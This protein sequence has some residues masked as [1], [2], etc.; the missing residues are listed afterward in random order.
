MLGE[1]L[2]NAGYQT[3]CVG[4]T[5]FFPQTK[6]CGFH[7]R[8]THEASQNFD[9]L[10]VNDYR[11]WLRDQS[12][13][14]F[15]EWGHGLQDNSWA[16]RPS[17]L[18]E[19]L[20]N[21][22]WTVTKAIEFLHRRD[23][24]RPYFL[25]VSFFHPHPPFCPPQ[26]FYD[27]YANRDL[28]DVPVG[29]WVD[30]SDHPI[31]NSYASHGVVPPETLAKTRRAYYAQLAHID[32]QIGRLMRACFND[33]HRTAERPWVIFTSDHGEMLG[34][35]HYFRKMFAF[36]G[37]ARIPMIISPPHTGAEV[38][39]QPRRIDAPVAI[40]DVY[41]TI[42]AMAGVEAPTE[43]DGKELLFNL[44][45]DPQECRNL[46]ELEEH[47]D[48]LEMW[49]GRMITELTGRGDGLTD[50]E[51]LIAGT[52]LPPSLPWASSPDPMSETRVV[53]E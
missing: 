35:H 45:D 26:A 47:A 6:H 18:P 51:K 22:T 28:P 10:F 42:L 24:T 33:R 7:S 31:Y 17:H 30:E 20:H 40:E 4:K 49:R 5:H 3:H 46:A 23:T 14:K 34:D 36:E 8:D 29:D 50:G 16:A 2:S 48:T 15:E 44:E 38:H 25:N 19:H 43:I 1:V 32:S 21:N 53:N 39:D 37:S 9:G 13:G 12:G 27:I 11:E 52:D 41:P